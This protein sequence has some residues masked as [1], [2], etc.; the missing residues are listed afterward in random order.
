MLAL[1]EKTFP[2]FLADELQEQQLAAENQLFAAAV[3]KG[4]LRT[5]A[6]ARPAAA[7][8]AATA[9]AAA[10]AAEAKV[11]P[12]AVAEAHSLAQK[13]ARSLAEEHNALAIEAYG[14]EQYGMAAEAL[15]HAAC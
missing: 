11:V 2:A 10:A 15:G 13:E 1:F 5:G 6:A 9:T 14:L 4:T 8:A 3:A 12:A 7:A